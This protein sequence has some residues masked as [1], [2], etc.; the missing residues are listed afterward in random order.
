[1]LQTDFGWFCILFSL[2]LPLSLSLFQHMQYILCIS[3]ES[4]GQIDAVNIVWMK[5]EKTQI[6]AFIQKFRRWLFCMQK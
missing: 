1:M 3:F 4:F 5:K 6:L 2:T